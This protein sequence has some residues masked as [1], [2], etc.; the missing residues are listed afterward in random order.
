[1]LKA[2]LAELRAA[3]C[4]RGRQVRLEWQ[5]AQEAGSFRSCIARSRQGGKPCPAWVCRLSRE[6]LVTGLA[7]M[8]R[9]ML[10]QPC[11][12]EPV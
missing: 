5:G 7:P 3:R 8:G 9:A 4:Q 11:S 2:I 10:L 6:P 12:T 1:V